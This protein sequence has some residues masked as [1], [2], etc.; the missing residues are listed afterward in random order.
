MVAY[1]YIYIYCYRGVI[2][3]FLRSGGVCYITN[4]LDLKSGSGCIQLF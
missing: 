2:E 1:I 4:R 3:L